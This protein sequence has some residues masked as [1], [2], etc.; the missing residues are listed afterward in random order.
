MFDECMDFRRKNRTLD[1]TTVECCLTVDLSA[2]DTQNRVLA[3]AHDAVRDQSLP[4]R[5][6]MML[7]ASRRRCVLHF[8]NPDQ[9]GE[10][11]MMRCHQYCGGAADLVHRQSRYPGCAL[12]MVV[13]IL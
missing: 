5:K 4:W 9:A 8:V 13:P 10:R 12:K 7:N 6:D 2:E 11:L 1:P 3:V